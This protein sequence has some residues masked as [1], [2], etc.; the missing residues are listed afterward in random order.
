M[1]ARYIEAAIDSEVETLRRTASAR[2]CAAFRAAAAVGGFV[3]GGAIDYSHAVDLLL[4]AA[5]ATGLPESEAR[6]HVE[7]GLAR[8]ERTPRV[9]PGESI[10]GY[11][12][13]L[14]RPSSLPPASDSPARPPRREVDVLWRAAVPV[15]A[16][17]EVVQW[18]CYRF[19]DEPHRADEQSGDIEGFCDRQRYQFCY[20]GQDA[21]IA[22][23]SCSCDDERGFC[24]RYRPLEII[25]HIELWDLCRAI[26]AEA[27]L[28]MWACCRG[29]SWTQTGHRLLFVL[30]DHEGRG[31]S[32]RARCIVPGKAPK[33]LAPAGYSVKG[34][35]LADPLGVQLLSGM[36]PSWWQ[37]RRVVISEGEADWLSWAGRQRETESE[38]PAFFG[39][40]AGSWS[41][42]IAKRIPDGSAV[43]LRTH[44]D[45]A[46]MRYAEQI[47]RS[48]RDRCVL[49]RSHPE[50]GTCDEG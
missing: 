8:G 36:V 2:A 14:R 33:S 27:K 45:A 30:R 41:P 46:G 39:V 38:G 42:E 7:R 17:P 34:L 16:D 5:T 40:E 15:S 48:L 1:R 9:L 28:P 47:E 50:G 12:A 32:L 21:P 35:L 19:S 49:Y 37:P 31:V 24:Y 43:V 44:H 4:N 18:L 25:Q 20:Q 6:R 26:P 22:A 10:S 13:P 23:G 3:S 29:G 11:R